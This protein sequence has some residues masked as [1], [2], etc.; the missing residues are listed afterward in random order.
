MGIFDFLGSIFGYAVWYF[1]DLFSNYGIAIFIFTVIMNL[2]M[3]PMIIK[4]Q[5][6]MGL[7]ASKSAKIN[8]KQQELKKLYGNNPR[9]YNEE[10]AA[11]YEKE[12]YNPMNM[13]CLAM[14]VP[15]ILMFSIYGVINRPLKNTLHIPQEKISQAVQ[16]MRDLPE[17]KDKLVRGYEELQIVRHFADIKDKLN[18]FSEEEFADIEEYSS[19]FNV[20]GIDLLKTPK[21]CKFSD[22]LWVIPVVYFV[23][24][25]LMYYTT[26]KMNGNQME[27]PGCAKFMPY[28]LPLYMVYLAYTAPG[29]VGF[30]W[31]LNSVIATG[32]NMLISKFYGIDKVNAKAQAE[33]LARM[34]IIE[35]SIDE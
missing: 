35:A 27:A 16:V 33:H 23:T 2:L 28:V 21:E 20:C 3:F 11:L 32:Q 10:V 13:G 31:I 5:S 25:I 14:L 6:S 29:A 9:K 19:G 17:T 22:M 34:E 12:N 18:M 30:F 8:K 7:A 26:K 15:M 24:S 1:F 4:R